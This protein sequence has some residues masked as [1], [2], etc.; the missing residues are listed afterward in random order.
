MRR[1]CVWMTA[2]MRQFKFLCGH[3]QRQQWEY[4][5]TASRVPHHKHYLIRDTINSLARSKGSLPRTNDLTRPPAVTDPR[6][7]KWYPGCLA[8]VVSGML[9]S[10]VVNRRQP[11]PFLID[12]GG[13]LICC[14]PQSCDHRPCIP[15]ETERRFY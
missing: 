9:H 11:D 4:S 14:L 12:G 3:F 7:Q 1:A 5:V 15:F 13:V 10:V 6:K 8:Q 2:S